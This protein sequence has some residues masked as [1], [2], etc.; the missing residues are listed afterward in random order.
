MKDTAYYL[1]KGFDRAMAEYF[2]SGRRR[3]IAVS[4]N[5]DFTLTLTFD[6]GEIRLYDCKPHIRPN[7]V[8]ASLSDLSCFN[9]VYLDEYH[10]VAW[11]I[12]PTV[13]SQVEWSN[14]V[15]LCP[16]TC[17][18]DSRPINEEPLSS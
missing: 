10:C 1:A 16:D 2:A 6:N 5:P 15:D 8:F 7:T 12:D 17:Y 13:D 11:D 9:R 18:V 14:K 3:L 4:P